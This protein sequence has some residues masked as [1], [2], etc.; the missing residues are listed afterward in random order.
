MSVGLRRIATCS[1]QRRISNHTSNHILM[2]RHKRHILT[3]KYML[4]LFPKVK[5]KTL[6]EGKKTV[7]KRLEMAQRDLD[8]IRTREKK[9]ANE[10]VRTANHNY[11]FPNVWPP[12][13][14]VHFVIKVMF[15]HTILYSYSY[16]SNGD[17]GDF[18][19]CSVIC[20]FLCCRVIWCQ[21]ESPFRKSKAS[22]NSSV[23]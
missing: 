9:L 22:L 20:C 21:R 16:C 17:K 18:L 5:L 1:S 13:S 4:L 6:E 12:C 10:K 3:W 23:H 14:S 2:E 15:R 8:N 19:Q 11:R 7:D